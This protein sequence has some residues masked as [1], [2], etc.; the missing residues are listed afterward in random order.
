MMKLT[1]LVYEIWVG[2]GIEDPISILFQRVLLVNN[3][4]KIT[5]SEVKI[6]WCN[7]EILQFWVNSIASIKTFKFEKIF[8][9]DL[10]IIISIS[11]KLIGQASTARIIHDNMIF[12]HNINSSFFIEHYLCIFF[13]II[14]VY[15]DV[16]Y[17][18]PNYYGI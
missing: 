10:D 1:L 4:S 5:L 8:F 6:V 18:I 16:R 12:L 15:F 2:K 7:N 11:L 9:T 14:R 17:N 3:N 13:N